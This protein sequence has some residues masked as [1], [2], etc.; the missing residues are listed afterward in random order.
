MK[1]RPSRLNPVLTDADLDWLAGKSYAVGTVVRSPLGVPLARATAGRSQ[2]TWVADRDNWIPADSARGWS[3]KDFGAVGDGKMQRGMSMTSGSAV[4][5]AAADAF[6]AAD[7]GKPIGVAAAGA[8]YAPLVTTISSYT[9]ARHVTLADAAGVAASDVMAS[10]GT[11]DS[12]AFTAAIAACTATFMALIVPPVEGHYVASSLVIPEGSAF[13]M[14]GGNPSCGKFSARRPD[15]SSNVLSGGAVTICNLPGAT[16]ALLTV[17]SGEVTLDG[18]YLSGNY[19]MSTGPALRV[20]SGD[21]CRPHNVLIGDVNGV[22]LD[23]QSVGNSLWTSVFVFNCGAND[24]RYMTAGM[25][26]T[27]SSATLTSATGVFSAGDVGKPVVV[28]GA[29]ASGAPLVGTISSYTDATHVTLSAAAD[30][31]VTNGEAMWGNSTAPAVQVACVSPWPDQYVNCF[32]LDEL[33]IEYSQG[34]SLE[35]GATVLGSGNYPEFLRIHK[36]HIESPTGYGGGIPNPWPLV[37][38][39]NFRSICL[40]DPFIYG[41]PGPAVRHEFTHGSASYYGGLSILGGT[42]LGRKSTSGYMPTNLVQL[43]TGDQF[44]MVG[45]RVD[46]Y[47]TQAVLVGSGYGTQVFVRDVIRGSSDAASTIVTDNRA[48]RTPAAQHGDLKVS[49]I[50]GIGTDPVAGVGLTVNSAVQ[51]AGSSGGFGATNYGTS[52]SNILKRANG[53]SASPSALASGDTIGLLGWDGHT[54]ASFAGTKA[55]IYAAATQ[56]WTS[57]HNGVGLHF[58]TTPNDS[59]TP[60]DVLVAD[61]SGQVQLPIQGSGAG[62]LI[63][64]DTN[65]YRDSADVLKTDD[66]LTVAGLLSTAAAA[67][68]GAGLRVP[69][70]TA[71]TSP[72]N[73]DVWSTTGG[74]YAQINGSTK[75]AVLADSSNQVG[76]GQAPVSGYSVAA[77]APM[78][79][80]GSTGYETVCYGGTPVNHFKQAGGSAGSPSASASGDTLGLLG[81][82][83]HTGSAF[84]TSKASVYAKATQAWTGSNQ[85]TQVIVRTTP[86]NSTSARDVLTVGQDA[87]VTLANATA[88][89]GTP[90]GAG[91]LYVESG[92][93]KFKGSSGTVTTIAAA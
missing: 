18:L 14:R 16:D 60:R 66:S 74:L 3:V 28:K 77:T 52:P 65:L 55:S 29:G 24:G 67:A 54:G 21:E 13:T 17:D 51:I 22:G 85:G 8:S 70:G 87:V 48:T 36:L 25:S 15:T 76:I 39:A 57:T 79:V 92:A 69:H 43:A 59:T 84:S 31:A 81:F 86:N 63:G 10:W 49:G 9:D 19:R 32:S 75:S 83:G 7:V 42:L 82:G 38:C 40:V 93:L 23:V 61:Q 2:S 26:M 88:P 78:Q 35:I 20:T 71:P 80:V 6:T 58:R 73:G 27:V 37:K 4:L 46:N 89:A 47:S 56:A 33:N 64:G 45:T 53:S 5:T 41:G 90:S 34:V 1:T 72:T 62:L 91:Y 68:G 11:D 12:A 30:T 50:A 44:V